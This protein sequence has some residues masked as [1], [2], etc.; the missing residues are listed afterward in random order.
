MLLGKTIDY[1]LIGTRYLCWGLGVLGLVGSIVL[2]AANLSLGIHSTA[3]FAAAFLLSVGVTL[4]LLPKQLAKGA[5][6]GK[7]KYKIGAVAL[8]LATAVMGIVYFSN[9][10]FPTLNLIFLTV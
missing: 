5:L 9:G 8:V 4:L 10:G 1:L 3:T 2:M 7:M 6:D